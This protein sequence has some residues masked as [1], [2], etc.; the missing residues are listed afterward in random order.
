MLSR[1]GDVLRVLRQEIQRI[2]HLEIAVRTGRE[3][4]EELLLPKLEQ[5]TGCISTKSIYPVQAQ[6]GKAV[7][8]GFAR[9]DLGRQVGGAAEA[10]QSAPLAIKG[11]RR[12]LH[13]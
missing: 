7:I 12:P 13:G 1:V 11:S 10:D 4:R 8:S 5:G 2:E 3:Q 9:K 6:F